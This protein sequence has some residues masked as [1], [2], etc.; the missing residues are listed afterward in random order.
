M[1][2]LANF[3]PPPLQTELPA[4]TVLALSVLSFCCIIFSL[5]YHVMSLFEVVVILEDVISS[6]DVLQCKYRNTLN[7]RIY[8]PAISRWMNAILQNDLHV[9]PYLQPELQK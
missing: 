2:K 6:S 3:A 9:V 5:I 4:D 7:I 1:T 8:F